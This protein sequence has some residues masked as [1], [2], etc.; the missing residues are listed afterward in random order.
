MT[1]VDDSTPIL[2]YAIIKA[3]PQRLGSNIK[4]IE[5]FLTNEQRNQQEG[6]RLTQLSVVFNKMI[7]FSRNDLDD[8]SPEEFAKKCNDAARGI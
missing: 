5:N 8:V 2:N 7:Q 4:F 6:A 1:G 3:Q